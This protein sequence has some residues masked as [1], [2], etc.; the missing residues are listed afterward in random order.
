[1]RKTCKTAVS[2]VTIET[3]VLLIDKKKLTNTLL[4]LNIVKNIPKSPRN[5]PIERYCLPPK[6]S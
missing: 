6:N 3:I 2:N 1:M 4:R 5:G